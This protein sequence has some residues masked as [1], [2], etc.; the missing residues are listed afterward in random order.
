MVEGGGVTLRHRAQLSHRTA[1]VSVRLY[2]CLDESVG[3]LPG[4]QTLYLVVLS[5]WYALRLVFEKMLPHLSERTRSERAAR[6][7]GGHAQQ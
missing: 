4:R 1:S 5:V 3:L 7:R 2:L 6:D